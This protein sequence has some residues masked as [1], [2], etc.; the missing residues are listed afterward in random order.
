MPPA[1]ILIVE[2]EAIAAENIAGRL[3]QQGYDVVGIVDSGME[4]IAKAGA[5]GPDLILMDIMLKGEMDGVAAATEISEQWQIPIVFMTAFGD[6]NT[7]QR[8]KAAEPLAY[9]IKPFKA[10]ELWA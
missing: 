4:A 1:R 9:L 3:R 8:A 5:I 6:E 7:L 2:D 10:H